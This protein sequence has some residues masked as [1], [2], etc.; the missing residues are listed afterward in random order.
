[1]MK[2]NICCVLTLLC[3]SAAG[4]SLS[5]TSFVKIASQNTARI[6][7]DFISVHSGL[8]NGSEYAEPRYNEDQFPFYQQV[9]WLPGEVTY[10][11]EHYSEVSLMYDLSTD[12]LVA[13]NPVNGQEIQL[14]KSRVAS[15]SLNDDQF[16]QVRRQDL[17]GL[18]QEGFYQ[19]LYDG[20]STVLVRHVKAFEEKIENNQV[21]FYYVDKKRI[22]V[23]T[24]D[25]YVR[26]AKK[27][28]I[29][30]MFGDNK[31]EVRGYMRKNRIKVSRRDPRSFSTLVAY[32]DTL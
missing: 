9:D 7:H 24:G 1:M 5:D 21:V 4:Q 3:L 27:G 14:V 12:N 31:D 18:P 2:S 29:L 25:S 10:N 32:Y 13:E 28:D 15:F 30:K 22:Y 20:K 6:Y 11:N 16:I 8:I 26:V 23:R 19:V 17:A